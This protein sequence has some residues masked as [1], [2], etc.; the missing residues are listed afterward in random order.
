MR[1]VDSQSSRERDP[2]VVKRQQV[3]TGHHDLDLNR[4]ESVRSPLGRALHR[5]IAAKREVDGL[6]V[7]AD[8]RSAFERALGNPERVD[9]LVAAGLAARGVEPEEAPLGAQRGNPFSVA[10][11]KPGEYLGHDFS[12][13]GRRRTVAQSDHMRR[14]TTARPVRTRT[15]GMDRAT[16]TPPLAAARIARPMPYDAPTRLIEWLTDRTAEWV[17][18]DERHGRQAPCGRF[19]AG[20]R[21]SAFPV[22][23]CG[24]L[25]D[26]P[27]GALVTP[28][29]TVDWLCLPAS[30]R[31][32][33]S[34]PWWTAGR[35][36][37]GFAPFRDQRP[38]RQD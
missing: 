23:H 26:C 16:L 3:L 27:T 2:L 8:A 12:D 22:E 21:G 36:A 10:G 9:Q 19:G 4:S 29:G 5:D 15:V 14:V 7:G 24:F 34:A 28:D 35:A 25:S 32:A 31:R 17:A 13:Y 18:R 37:S 6:R 11:G 33:C 38:E 30:T 1:K 20:Q